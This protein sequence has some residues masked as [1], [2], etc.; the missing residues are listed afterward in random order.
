MNRRSPAYPRRAYEEPR[1]IHPDS[2]ARPEAFPGKED[3]LVLDLAG[4]SDDLSIESLPTLFGLRQ[5]LDGENV[6][7]AL[8]REREEDAVRAREQL[9]VDERKVA[10]E[11]AEREKK[12]NRRADS[13][14]FF[15]RDRMY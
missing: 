7:Q 6:M 12:R 9:A 2:R 11:E 1:Q 8:E 4:A 13:I 15:S 3:C 5:L 14:R 10:E